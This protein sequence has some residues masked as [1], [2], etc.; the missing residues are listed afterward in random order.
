MIGEGF[1]EVYDEINSANA[2]KAFTILE[3]V[4]IVSRKDIEESHHIQKKMLAPTVSSAAEL[5]D[6]WKDRA[7]KEWASP[8]CSPTDAGRT[9]TVWPRGGRILQ[10]IIPSHPS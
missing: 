7:W 5:S 1:R 2:I 3:W 10:D 4:W 8:T 6:T 9:P